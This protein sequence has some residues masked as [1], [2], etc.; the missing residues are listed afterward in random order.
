MSPQHTPIDYIQWYQTGLKWR[1]RICYGLSFLCQ[2]KNIHMKFQIQ[3]LI[4]TAEF[5]LKTVQHYD[6]IHSHYLVWFEMWIASMFVSPSNYLNKWWL[7]VND[8]TTKKGSGVKVV[9]TNQLYWQKFTWIDRLLFSHH[10][11]PRGWFKFSYD[12]NTSIRPNTMT[13]WT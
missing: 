13:L 6:V 4:S 2:I 9:E 11:V 12:K 3:I 1:Y 7:S 10:F 5:A 8:I